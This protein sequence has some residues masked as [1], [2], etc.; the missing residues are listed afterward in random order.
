MHPGQWTKDQGYRAWL[1]WRLPG[2]QGVE[3]PPTWVSKNRRHC[4]LKQE[5]AEVGWGRW[6][7]PV[8]TYVP[9]RTYIGY[10]PTMTCTTFDWTL[11]LILTRIDMTSSPSHRTTYLL[12]CAEITQ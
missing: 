12:A 9:A 6:C 8:P 3:G 11:G 1:A 10:L 2:R 5:V 7:G 4:R